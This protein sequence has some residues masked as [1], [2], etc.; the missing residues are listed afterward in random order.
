MKI[1]VCGKG[2]SG[3][4]TISAL[5]AKQMAKTKNVLVLDIDESNYGLHSQLGLAAPRDLMEYFGGKKG[6]KEKQKAPKTSSLGGLTQ[7][8]ASTDPQQSRFFKERWSFSDLP[9]E[10]VEEKGNLKLMAVG[11]IHDYGEGC[12]CPMGVL[13]REFLENLDL[14]KD[15]IVIVDTEAGTEHFGR[16]VDKNFDLILVVIDP[17]SESLRLSKKFNE[18]GTQCGCGVYFVLN[19][20]EPDI[21]EDVL[22]SVN[23]TNVVAEIPAK[24]E[25]FKASLKGEE[26][27]FELEEIVKLAEFLEKNRIIKL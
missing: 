26:L 21:R 3:K 14:G 9:T 18:F 23:C 19:K 22:A 6:F 7:M 8:G 2:G 13:T 11:K 27:D 24:R 15:D 17:S 10:F 1:A 12:A 5:L 20:V 25:L 16:G 4:S